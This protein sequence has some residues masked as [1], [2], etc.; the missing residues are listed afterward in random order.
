MCQT[1]S[2]PASWPPPDVAPGR[3][4]EIWWGKEAWL[5][6]LAEPLGLFPWVQGLAQPL[7]VV[8]APEMRL[9]DEVSVAKSTKLL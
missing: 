7:V 4:H 1:G 9:P 6:I 8:W 5:A 2:Y 3:W